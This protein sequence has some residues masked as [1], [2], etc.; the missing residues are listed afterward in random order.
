MVPAL[1]MEVNMQKRNKAYRSFQK[2]KFLKRT[3]E[4]LKRFS[5]CRI[6][7]KDEFDK[8]IDSWAVKRANNR[9]ICSCWMCGNPRKYFNDK[10]LNEK[11]F[12]LSCEEFK[13]EI[14]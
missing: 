11:R 3:K 12:E 10:S 4:F 14:E 1:H 7:S 13:G 2:Q 9:K 5:T 8:R 6:E